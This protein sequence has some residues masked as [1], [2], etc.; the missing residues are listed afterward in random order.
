[1]QEAQVNTFIY[2]LWNEADNILCSFGLSED[3]KKTAKWSKGDL[4]VTSLNE[5]TS[6]M[7][8]LN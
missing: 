5:G 7:K 6:I 4:I 8:E 1:M 3:D 2:S